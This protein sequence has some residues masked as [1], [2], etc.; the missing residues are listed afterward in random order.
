MRP[1]L[2][3]GMPSGVRDVR[4]QA[5]SGPMQGFD[6]VRIVSQILSL[7]ALHYLALS[8]IIPPLLG[9][10]SFNKLALNFQ[11]G[12]TS[13]SMVLDWRE[14]AG[15]PILDG[16]RPW[17]WNKYKVKANQH[18]IDFLRES[19]LQTSDSDKDRTG[20]R[21]WWEYEAFLHSQENK[22]IKIQ[23]VGEIAWEGKRLG[24]GS[25][26]EKA[27][28]E[29]LI[30]EAKLA[31]DAN[32]KV[33]EKQR[34]F[35]ANQG[36]WSIFAQ[37]SSRGWIIVIAWAL[38]G[39]VDVFLLS[40]LIRRP[41]HILDHTITLHVIHLF[42]TWFYT[43]SFPTSLFYWMVM[44]GHIGATVVWAE[45]LSIR[46]EM[47][48]GFQSGLNENT[49]TERARNRNGN[50]EEEARLLSSKDDEQTK[51]SQHR[52]SNSRSAPH[53]LFDDEDQD[54]EEV[55]K[56]SKEKY[57]NGGHGHEE[58]EMKRID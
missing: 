15:D 38:A 46:R 18:D 47:K 54:D 30:M 10:L 31:S 52:T 45:A 32:T 42:L 34:A 33:G 25:I 43:R 16:G 57:R 53:V 14:I 3:L 12:P 37:D 41:T 51:Q 13:L 4:W 55:H 21:F 28:A 56:N 1:T 50:N 29:R 5:L 19:N 40:I 22:F 20:T 7:Q 49:D 9:L 39:A 23:D 36:W 24:A 2:H 44:A 26:L 11:G 17:P 6:A 27:A 48:S 8:F 35:Y 58:I